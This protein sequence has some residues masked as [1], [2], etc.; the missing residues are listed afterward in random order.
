MNFD[1]DLFLKA[2]GLAFILEAVPVML[3]PSLYQRVL[4]EAS[5][6]SPEYL[7]KHGL[8]GILIGMAL[9]V[10]GKYLN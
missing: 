4:E 5:R 9:L 8:A 1:L 3:V 7:R 10:I 6:L 2:L